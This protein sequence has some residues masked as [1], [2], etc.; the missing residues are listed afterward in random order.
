MSLLNL[1][2]SAGRGPRSKK[3]LKMFM[4]AGLLVAVLGIGSTLAA[5][6]T[7]NTPGGDTE[8]GQGI[9]QTVYCGGD[10]TVDVTP[11]SSFSN[12]ITSNLSVKLVTNGS[13]TETS[14]HTSYSTLKQTIYGSTNT[15]YPKFNSLTTNISGWWV[16][17][18]ST[19]TPSII[20]A[21]L[22]TNTAPANYP[23]SFTAGLTA[24][25]WYFIQ[26]VSAGKFKTGSTPSSTP[27]SFSSTPVSIA[28][29]P[30]NFKFSGLVI[31]NIPTACAGVNFVFSG[32]GDSGSAKTLVSDISVVAAKWTGVS[33]SVTP[34]SDRTCQAS[35]SGITATQKS[36]S[37]TFA[38]SSGTLSAKELAKVVVETQEDALTGNSCSS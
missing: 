35:A 34:S 11:V 12:G 33:G 26:E 25:N 20:T 31:S 6:I 21:A 19:P 1:N 28:D 13:G 36:S 32:Y 30:A 4:G 29:D 16:Y 7:L 22:N 18:A 10:A 27:V 3:S 17:S 15:R 38:I 2:T 9:T 5:N 8:F 37:L 23:V 24:S 14:V